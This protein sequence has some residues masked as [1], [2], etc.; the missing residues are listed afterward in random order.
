MMPPSLQTPGPEPQPTSARITN[1]LLGGSYFTGADEKAAAELERACPG[2]RRAAMDSRLFTARAVAWAADQGIT[3]FLDLGAGISPGP[4]VHEIARSVRPAARICYVDSDPEVTDW[5]RDVAPGGGGP[6]IAVVNADLR[7]PAALW[8]N[9]ELREV[10]D[11]GRPVCVVLAGVLHFQPA[12]SARALVVSYARLAAPGSVIAV[13]VQAVA[14][15]LEW[16]RLA[17]VH[18]VGSVHNF[19]PEQVAGL[20]GGLEIVPPG[21]RGAAGLRPGWADCPAR[22]SAPGMYT[23]SG[24]GRKPG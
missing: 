16:R 15:E 7:H 14:G 21:V 24:I 11:P 9:G 12:L 2:V 4:S 6:G 5:I 3:Q 10:I 23:L 17:R 8:H 19:S 20:L 1:L 18:P 13:S 22:Q